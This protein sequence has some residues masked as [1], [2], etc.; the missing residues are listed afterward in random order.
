MELAYS[1]KLGAAFNGKIEETTRSPEFIEYR[2]NVNL[3]LTSPPFILNKKKKYGNLRGNE[4]IDWLSGLA[5]LFKDYLTDDGSIVI[6]LGNAWEPGRPVMSTLAIRALL[7]FLEEGDLQLCQQFV[8]NNIAKLPTPA[9]WVN[10]K[11]IRVKD[12]FTYIWWMSKTDFPKA[13][14]RKVLKE[15]ST[16]M[17]KLLERQSYNSGRRPSQHSI[18]ETSFLTNNK[19]AIPSNVISSSNTL[20]N[21]IYQRFCKE[22]GLQ[23]HP[24]RMPS[25]IVEFFINF[26]TEPGDLVMDPFGGSNTTGAMAEKLGRRWISIEPVSE[27]IEG[28]KGRFIKEEDLGSKPHPRLSEQK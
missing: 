4:Y 10:V 28:S 16:S 8:W 27:Y 19:G 1:T 9:Q 24:A 7:A 13:D 12:S 6:E 17:K 15:Y 5:I 11:R 21:S 23:P 3:I 26:L 2:H 18:G 25:D 20:S 22:Q 14:N